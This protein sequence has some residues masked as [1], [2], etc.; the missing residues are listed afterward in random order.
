MQPKIVDI[1]P[2]N[3]R[4]VSGVPGVFIPDLKSLSSIDCVQTYI[5]SW[6][7]IHSCIFFRNDS[8]LLRE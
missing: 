3:Y 8:A 5:L 4:L 6:V 7:A 2:W 1:P